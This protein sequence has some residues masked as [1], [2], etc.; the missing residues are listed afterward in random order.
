M[1]TTRP[2][3]FYLATLYCVLWFV[4]DRA[5]LNW[6][7]VATAA[8]LFMTLII[9]R[10]ERRDTQAIHAKLDNLLIS[11]D[12]ASNELSQIDKMQPE[13]IERVRAD[14]QAKAGL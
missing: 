6:N 11:H 7:G 12:K 4:F 14:T 2:I 3:A 1:L 5:S 9:Q 10:A 13:E 8:T